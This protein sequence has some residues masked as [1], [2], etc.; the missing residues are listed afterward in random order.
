VI[1]YSSEDSSAQDIGPRVAVAEG[2]TGHVYV[3]KAGWLQLPRDIDEIEETAR[4][5]GDVAMII[6]DP[7][8]NHIN[9]ANSDSETAVREAI[10]PLNGLADSLDAVV[11][12][13]R[14][15]SEKEI[16]GGLI[17]AILGSS[18]W[19]QVPRVVIGIVEDD[20]HIRH[21]RVGRGNRV[22]PGEDSLTFEVEGVPREGY[23]VDITHVARMGTSDKNIDALL[24]GENAESKS[25]SALARDAIID[26]LEKAPMMQME[27]DTLDA[28]IVARCGVSTKTV[29]NLRLKLK[30]AGFLKVFPGKDESGKVTRWN[31]ARTLAPYSNEVPRQEE[32]GT[33]P[34]VSQSPYPYPGADTPA[35]ALN[36]SNPDQVLIEKK[37]GTGCCEGPGENAPGPGAGGTGSWPHASFREGWQFDDPPRGREVADGAVKP[38]PFEDGG[39]WDTS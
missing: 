31:V 6:I 20:E 12:G 29:K 15:L 13:T 17:S 3:V 32:D 21:I 14:H 33:W 25:K 39:A 18:A 24:R 1:W 11:I 23:E 22:P 35:T 5:I 27:S 7:L 19:V 38:L 34:G 36:K 8:G 37:K 2:D 16:R 28:R 30:D 10:S 26:E 4:E 9:G